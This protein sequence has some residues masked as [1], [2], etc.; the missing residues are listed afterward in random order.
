M[1]TAIHSCSL[2]SL[3]FL[4]LQV[5]YIPSLKV[6]Y[7]TQKSGKKITDLPEEELEQLAVL[8]LH[9]SHNS[10]TGLPH[11]LSLMPNLRHLYL[12]DNCIGH[13]PAELCSMQY[14]QVITLFCIGEPTS[15]SLLG[16][17]LMMYLFISQ[18]ICLYT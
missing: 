3:P 12:N 1:Y 11:T 7:L 16:V 17:H 18:P 6:L 2:S 14:L 10:L 15:A 8:E 13:L 5:C 9:M 4:V